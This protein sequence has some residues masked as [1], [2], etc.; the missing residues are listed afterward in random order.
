MRQILSIG[1]PVRFGGFTLVGPIH[2]SDH[3]G[4]LSRHPFIWPAPHTA[5]REK[6]EP[7]FNSAFLLERDMVAYGGVKREA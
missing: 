7:V 2:S 4:H 6:I 3:K 5:E 1:L